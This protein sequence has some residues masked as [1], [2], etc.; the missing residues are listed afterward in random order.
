MVD[1]DQ[2]FQK[3]GKG[4]SQ[5][6]SVSILSY[7]PCSSG[8]TDQKQVTSNKKVERPTSSET[9]ELKEREQRYQKVRKISFVF[10][11]LFST[12]GIVASCAN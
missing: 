2:M 7:S 9:S 1:L 3:E 12:P 6:S 8:N 10:S 5:I 4:T 11:S